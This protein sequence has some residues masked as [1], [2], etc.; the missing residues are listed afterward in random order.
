M[1]EL[2]C[3][4]QAVFTRNVVDLITHIDSLGFF[5]TF[6]EVYRTVDQAKLYA[7][8]GLGIQDSL[9]CKR[10]AVDLNIFDKDGNILKT[11]EDYE[12]FGKYWE[13]LNPLNRAGVFW[14]RKDLS[15]FEMR[16][17]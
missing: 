2:L 7:S 4:K 9:H 17:E 3:R 8:K 10:L 6:G 16:D 14:K 12:P 13:S 11:S 5:V 1:M 15:H